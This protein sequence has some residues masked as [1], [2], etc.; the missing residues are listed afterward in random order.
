MKLKKQEGSLMSIGI[1]QPY[2]FPHLGHFELIYRTDHWVCFDLAQYTAKTWMNRNRIMH[3]SV[4]WQYINVAVKKQSLGTKV[5]QIKIVDKSKQFNKL[6]GQ[7]NHYK[8]KAPYYAEVIK[9]VETTFLQCK[10]DLLFELN[11]S[12]LK[13]VCNYLNINFV[14]KLSSDFIGYMPS[15][16][17]P[18]EWA[19]NIA[20]HLKEKHYINPIGGKSI[21]D[22]KKYLKENIKLSFLDH[23]TSNLQVGRS[24][25]KDES[26]SILDVMMWNSPEVILDSFTSKIIDAV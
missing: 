7:L 25:I 8:S 20:K 14:Y 1:M 10:S 21:F 16:L 3:P 12:S 18:D 23:N 2:F 22:K 6:L 26:L 9:I 19:L 13:T 4:S 5:N 11:I 17:E 15:Q 24:D